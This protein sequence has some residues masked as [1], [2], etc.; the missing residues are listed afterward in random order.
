M[1]TSEGCDGSTSSIFE[2]CQL[3]QVAVSFVHCSYIPCSNGS[4]GPGE[5]IIVGLAASGRTWLSLPGMIGLCTGSLST[6]QTVV[7]LGMR[8]DISVAVQFL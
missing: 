2:R 7:S 6:P 1:R 5:M 3:L 4:G 8:L